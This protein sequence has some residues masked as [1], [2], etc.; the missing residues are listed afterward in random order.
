MRE[1]FWGLGAANRLPEGELK[2]ED[3]EVTYKIKDSESTLASGD[4][5]EVANPFRQVQYV[6][7]R[8]QR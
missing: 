1:E 5:G 8:A 7:L 6:V 3:G 4:L 2:V